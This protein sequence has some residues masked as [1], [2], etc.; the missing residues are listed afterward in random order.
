MKRRSKNAGIQKKLVVDEVEVVKEIV[1]NVKIT[2][3]AVVEVTE[4]VEVVKIKI[5]AV[6]VIETVTEIVIV[7]VTVIVIV[8]VE[9][10][11]TT[12]VI[13]TETIDGDPIIA[14]VAGREIVTVGDPEV[15]I[16]IQAPK[17]T[18]VKVHHVLAL[19]ILPCL[20][21]NMNSNNKIRLRPTNL[22]NYFP[23]YLRPFFKTNIDLN[24]YYF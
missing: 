6:E 21:N 12:V 19:L 5:V 18:P 13:E 4:T 1:E 3:A 24:K 15:V 2:T 16:E 10:I 22:N 14:D 17:K 9:E 8:I 7:I 20:N 23:P 11:E